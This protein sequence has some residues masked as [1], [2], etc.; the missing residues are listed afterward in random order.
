MNPLLMSL[1]E[2]KS[3]IEFSIRVANNR[4]PIIVGTGGN[5]TKEVINL[6]KFAEKAG[7]DALLIVTPYY[8][9]TTQKVFWYITQKLPENVNIPLFFIM[10]LVGQVL[11]L[12]LI[13]V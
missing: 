7:A 3:V 4:I 10:Y 13:H 11:I 6:S 2:K 9:K 1:D 12:N 8:N 5:N